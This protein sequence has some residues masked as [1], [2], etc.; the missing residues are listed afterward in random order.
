MNSFLKISSGE[1]SEAKGAV[2]NG[3]LAVKI[4]SGFKSYGKYSVLKS[5]DLNVPQGAM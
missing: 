1:K 4:S 3:T 2:K 5:L